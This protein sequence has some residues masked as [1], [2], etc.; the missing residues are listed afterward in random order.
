MNVQKSTRKSVLFG[1]K[2]EQRFLLSACIQDISP[3][4]SLF[5]ELVFPIFSRHVQEVAEIEKVMDRDFYMD[6]E[7]AIDFGVVDKVLTKRPREDV[8][9]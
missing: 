5:F 8:G 7:Q 6:A 9:S 4:F 2:I 1:T 3:L